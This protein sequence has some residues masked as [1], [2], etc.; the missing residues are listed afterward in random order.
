MD[1]VKPDAMNSNS[2]DTLDAITI[3]RRNRTAAVRR[4]V[5]G[6]HVASAA[7]RPRLPAARRVSPG[8]DGLTLSD[9]KA[10]IE[11]KRSVR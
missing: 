4:H 10:Y 8:I 1:S 9:F 6:D 3:V 2:S 11:K 7:G 5:Q